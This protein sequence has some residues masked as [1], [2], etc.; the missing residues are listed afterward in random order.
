MCFCTSD[1]EC[2]RALSCSYKIGN[3]APPWLV[4]EVYSGLVPIGYPHAVDKF[5]DNRVNVL[6]IAALY[7]DAIALWWWLR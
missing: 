3:S 1:I 4:F 2:M 7:T 6:Q 5:V